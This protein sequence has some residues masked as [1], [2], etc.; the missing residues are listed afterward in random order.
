[1]KKNLAALLIVTFLI[2]GCSLFKKDP[3]K[4]VNEGLS[5]FSDVKKMSYSFVMN[6]IVKAP[7]GEKPAKTQFDLDISGKSDAKDKDFLKGDMTV[8]MNISIDDQKNSA[9][10]L[11]KMLDKKVF[12]NL[13][14]LALAGISSEQVK[15]QMDPVLNTWWSL[16]GEDNLFSELTKEQADIK[17]QFKTTEFF[18][19]AS[20]EGE[21]EIDGVKTIRYRVELDKEA[22][23]KFLM[24][25]ARLSDNQLT[26]EEEIA[27]KDSLKDLEFSGAAWVGDDDILHRIKGTVAASPK[28]GAI[29]SFDID[30][31]AWNYEEDVTVS[32]PETSKEFNP[33]ALL[34][35]LGAFGSFSQSDAA[36]T[37]T[38]SSPID[39]PLG[40]KQV[41]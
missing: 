40:S 16:A 6:G 32:A 7:A 37:S 14:K 13:T 3:Q 38:V 21:E 5:N 25:I 36:G 26:P 39:N 22:L 28:Q 2:S 27:M 20:E 8:K 12:L 17:E 15:A 1:M 9:E 34:P 18:T 33:L 41:K 11:V 29:S 35:V 23:Q 30:Y 24:D 31:R 19:N 4:A 10:L